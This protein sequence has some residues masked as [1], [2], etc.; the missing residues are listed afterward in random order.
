VGWLAD[1]YVNS[2]FYRLFQVKPEEVVGHLIYDLGN[3][4]WD[5]ARLRELE[6]VLPKEETFQGFR[7]EHELPAI[8]RRTLL[9]NN[10]T[11]DRKYRQAAFLSK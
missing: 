1:P 3:R 11:K 7:V 9:P 4:Q 2:A 6:Q 10:S 8:G 5:I